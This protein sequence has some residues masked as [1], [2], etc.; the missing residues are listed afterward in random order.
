MTHDREAHNK[1][2]QEPHD[3]GPCYFRPS[4]LAGLSNSRP[5][6]WALL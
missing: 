6:R 1:T 4:A 3:L 5:R 2:T